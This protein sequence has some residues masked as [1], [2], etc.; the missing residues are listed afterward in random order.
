MG[1]DTAGRNTAATG[2]GAGD[3]DLNQLSVALGKA[4]WWILVPTV[5]V[6]VGVTVAVSTSA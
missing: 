5:I 4:R 1:L 6:G 3:L 2:E